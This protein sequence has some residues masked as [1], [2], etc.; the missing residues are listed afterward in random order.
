M[1]NF[2]E[3]KRLYFFLNKALLY[4]GVVI[5]NALIYKGRPQPS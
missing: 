2:K 5:D 4:E 3:P 1:S